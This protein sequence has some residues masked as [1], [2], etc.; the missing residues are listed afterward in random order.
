M[1]WKKGGKPVGTVDPNDGAFSVVAEAAGNRFSF[2]VLPH[3]GPAPAAG[4][5][6]VTVINQ[7]AFTMT[8]S[9]LPLDART[10]T[11]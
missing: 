4:R 3:V 7:T 2:E 10:A 11:F 8:R 1:R 5:T 6:K 9:L